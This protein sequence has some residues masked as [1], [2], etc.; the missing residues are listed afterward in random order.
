MATLAEP[1]E[2][3]VS[4]VKETQIEQPKESAEE[5]AEESPEETPKKNPKKTTKKAPRKEPKKEPKKAPKVS[6]ETTRYNFKSVSLDT[7]PIFFIPGTS[8]RVYFSR[9]IARIIQY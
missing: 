8:I 2:L 1:E 3:E 6:R 7:R 9:S 4:I 5:S